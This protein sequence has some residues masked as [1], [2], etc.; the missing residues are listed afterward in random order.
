MTQQTE[1]NDHMATMK[2]IDELAAA[3]AANL[4]A[5]AGVRGAMEEEQRAILKKHRPRLV[6]LAG[7]AKQARTNL[8]D[9]IE[10]SP[11][12]FTKPRTV[13]LHGLKLGVQKQKGN[14]VWDDEAA[15]IARI[16]KLLPADQAELLIRVKESV[17]KPGVYDLVAGDLKRLGIRIEGDGDEVLIKG[18]LSD[19]DK[20]LEAL[21]KDETEEAATL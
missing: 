15:V 19:L 18:A 4:E 5:L 20:W 8:F 21:L 6:K 17:H 10:E 14:I 7:N 2:L 13:I 12:L 3:Y 9:A 11:D 1:G 16:K